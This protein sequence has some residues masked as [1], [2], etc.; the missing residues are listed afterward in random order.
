[1]KEHS[2]THFNELK[3]LIIT[4]RGENGCPWDKKQTLRSVSVYLIEE[5]YELVDAIQ[6]EDPRLIAEELGDVL[7]QIFFISQIF[8]ESSTFSLGKIIAANVEKM[9]RRHPHV[10]GDEKIETAEQVKSRWRQ[11]KQ[12]E[13]EENSDHNS[14]LN[15]IPK[16]LPALLRAYRVSERAAGTGFDWDTIDEVMEQVKEEWVEFVN[17]VEADDGNPQDKSNVSMEFGDILFSLVN[18]ARFAKIHPETALF[19]SINKFEKRFNF[20]EKIVLKQGRKL[21]D[22]PKDQL[23]TLWQ[24]A[25]LST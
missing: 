24:R 12:Q 2:L 25:K 17:E 21:E 8:S 9:K 11:I 1:M 23:H 10:F 19:D 14:I 18:V 7:F 22:L 5:V 3:N 16:S 4:L 20:M 15:S 13:K 6:S